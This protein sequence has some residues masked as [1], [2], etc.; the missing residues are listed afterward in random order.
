MGFFHTEGITVDPAS[1]NAHVGGIERKIRQIKE[2]IRALLNTLPYQL[3]SFLLS[4]L[5][6]DTVSRMNLSPNPLGNLNI[7]PREAFLG[8]KTDYDRDLRVGFGDVVE[9]L[10]SEETSNSL[11]ERTATGI[12]V[13]HKSNLSRSIVIYRPRVGKRGTFVTRGEFKV[14]DVI[15]DSFIDH[16]NMLC[17]ERGETKLPQST[18]PVFRIGLRKVIMQDIEEED[19]VD[20]LPEPNI[21]QP[22]PVTADHVQDTE[23]E[24]VEPQG[25]AAVEQE[26]QE[27]K[28]A[29]PVEQVAEPQMEP[30]LE[31]QMPAQADD[32]PEPS[33]AEQQTEDEQPPPPRRN[34]VRVGRTTYKNRVYTTT[35]DEIFH[36]K[37][38]RDA[39]LL[40]ITVD[41]AIEKYGQAALSSIIEEI[42]KLPNMDV[43]VPEDWRKLSN[44]ELRKVIRSKMFLKAKFLPDGA[45][46]KLK[47]RLVAGGH[48]QN[49]S[50]YDDVSS[51]TIATQSAFML[52]A[53][54]AKEQRHVVVVDIAS[55]YLNAKMDPGRKVRMRLEPKLA[56][57]L[58]SIDAK[59][60]AFLR[61]D[62]SLIVRLT[63]ALYGL[64]ESAKLW[65]EDL[66]TTLESNGMVPNPYDP[67]VF[68]K[69]VGGVQIT[70]GF[71]VDDLFISS[72]SAELIDELLGVLKKRYKTITEH[73]GKV[74]NYLGM[75][76]D[77]RMPGRVQIK[78][79]KYVEDLL[80]KYGVRG[81]A[82]TPATE[83]L[84][85][86][87]LD[88]ALLKGP[89]AEAFH[90]A[91]A[92]LLYLAKK[93]RG[94]LL[95]AVSFL[96]TRV[97]C[98]TEEDQAKLDRVLKYLNGTK[99]LFLTL[100][101]GDKMEVNAYVDA[102]YGVHPG[103]KGH[104][105][106]V[107]TLGKG[108]VSVK[109][110]KQ[111]LV[112]KSSTESELIALSDEFSSVLWTKNFLG[113]DGQGYKTGPAKVFEDNMSAI[114]LAE[115]G[116]ST[117]GRTR[118]IDIRYFF[119][120]DRIDSGE[121]EIEHKGTS[122]M[123]ADMLTKPLQGELFRKMRAKLLNTI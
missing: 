95:P 24:I 37:W 3:P 23:R 107:I 87:D 53:I 11:E 85:D 89:N 20:A 121:I 102:S 72:K 77:F 22:E 60:K 55:A 96:T 97:T 70:T 111:K 25:G 76:M 48:M 7:S 99:E 66:K 75:Q 103:A 65:Y 119:I 6:Q 78:M 63:K 16:M 5:V 120:K 4:K 38:D 12:C 56:T 83:D 31:P 117:S 57:I 42:T 35:V 110:A 15:P 17:K 43:I 21:H 68:N 93:I 44:A 61:K 79:T 115:K 92:T 41:E 82:K 80:Q 73:H 51:P 39:R 10:V 54:A 100:E 9:F 36:V 88:S 47:A 105:G 8:M 13:L 45:F 109:S 59:Y 62:G 123:I 81:K 2:R 122:E 104:T 91:V 46:D 18:D 30:Q 58:C 108:A 101:V 94:D 90:S 74:H 118:H 67:C 28:E 19:N 98:S 50:D 26:A 40:N 1:P 29:D 114:S 14:L 52:A 113:P 27:E 32:A 64:I 33:S 69:T 71:H 106:A 112:A 86:I 84:F 49:R 34:P 116:R